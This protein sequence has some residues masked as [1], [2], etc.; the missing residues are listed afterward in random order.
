MLFEDNI[1]YATLK[2]IL[3]VTGTLGMMCSTVKLRHGAK[4]I[5]LVFSLYLCYVTVSSVAIITIFGYTS[6]LR[7]FLFTISAPAVYLVFRLAQVTPSKAVFNYATQILFS[8]YVSASITLIN[9]AV[10][11]S[12][13]TD[14]L[15]RLAAY[16]LIIAL[17]YRFLR[18]PFLRLAAITEKGWL[19]LALIPCSLMIFSVALATYPVSYTENPTNVIFMYL[20]GAVIIVIYF[21]IFQYLFTQYRLQMAK[22]DLELLNFQLGYLKEKITQD[23][24]YAE[25]SR[26]DR[27][28]MRHR[29]QTVS[30][31]LENG[32]TAEALAY[33]RQSI[34]QL[35]TKEPALFCKDVILNATLASYFGQAKEAGI[36]L[37]TRLSIP[38]MLPVHSG[39]FSIAIANALENAVKACRS[40]P[41]GQRK[42]I[43]KCI[44]KPR[45]ML[46]ISNPYS[47]PVAFSEDGLPLSKEEGHGVGARSIMAFCK[48]YDAFCSFTAKDGWFQLKILL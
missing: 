41:A 29:L 25:K 44:H 26:I 20:F 27:H 43:F 46:E 24:L 3:V 47:G 39:E 9:A 32:N 5:A 6:F 17:E 38:E 10:H 19:I 12:T 1:P 34:S 42:I 35:H 37:E 14:F 45:L 8:M 18:R 28:D 48:K 13:L 36:V 40:L 7:V 21:S 4:R 15:M 16:G 22:Q 30:S 11:G 23:T 2:I 31:L 33:V